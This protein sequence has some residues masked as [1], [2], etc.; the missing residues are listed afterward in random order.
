MITTDMRDYE[1]FIYGEEDAYG[2]VTLSEEVKGSV[3]MAINIASQSVQDNILY[4]DCSYVG[5]THNKS[6][7][8][9]YVIKYGNE[10]LKVHYVN[11]KGRYNQVFMGVML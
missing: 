4:K 9:T 5:L 1:Y 7:D 2:Q 8:D 11:P 3:R 10:K 6:I